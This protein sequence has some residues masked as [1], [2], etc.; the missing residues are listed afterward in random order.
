MSIDRIFE[1]H[2]EEYFRRVEREVIAS[3]DPS[4][5]AVIA[6]GGGTFVDE[7]NRRRLAELG[8]TVC[9]VTGLD[10]IMDRVARNSKR[11]LA[12]GDGARERL[13]RL[14]EERMPV[15]RQADVL[16]ETDALSIEQSVSRV[17]NMIEPRL[18]SDAEHSG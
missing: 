14:L 1:H 12:Q 18:K 6:T 2:G 11:P 3:L 10:T 13:E 5:P 16:I 7:G 8:V 4:T 15:Y 17:L 9:L